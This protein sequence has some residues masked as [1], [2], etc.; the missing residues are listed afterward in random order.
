MDLR[1]L[2]GADE[3]GRSALLVNDALLLDYGIATGNPPAF[4]LD[5]DPEAVVVSHGHLDHVGNVPALLAGRERPDVHCTPP[6]YDLGMALARDTLRLHGGTPQCPFTA[7]E[8]RRLTAAAT[9]HGYRESFRAAGHEVT[10]FDAGHIPGSAHVL[11]DDGGTCLLY[12]GDFNDRD[13]R[14][15]SGT[16]AR[17]DADVVVTESTYAET[18]HDQRRAIESALVDRVQTTLR[19]GGTALLPAFAIGRTQEVLLICEANGI[20]PFVDGMGVRVTGTLRD[21]PDYLR[22]GEALRRAWSNARVVDGPGQRD[23]IAAANEA[24]VTTAGM[25][26]GGPV[27][28]YLNELR[29]DP[30]HTVALTGYQVAGTPGR[31]LLD[32]GRCE[33][34][35]VVRP[36]A[37]SVGLFDLSAHAD[38]DGLRAFL[39]PYRDATV[40]TVHG[41]A[42]GRFAEDLRE[43][44]YDARA[45]TRGDVISIE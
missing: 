9:T 28:T 7:E 12:T 19:Q 15:V 37:P 34:D 14:L 42:T 25:L 41:D 39:D 45:P 36:V 29:T 38:A 2:G 23:R 10:L 13:Q 3:V 43:D 8:V 6:T 30:V 18:R 27:V 17:P 22:D 5:C 26:A 11:V 31:Q 32:T 16:T 44:G 1:F 35:G 24:I 4:P 20:T 33:L 40:L 21:H